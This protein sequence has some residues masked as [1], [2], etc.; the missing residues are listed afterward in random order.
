M[1][2]DYTD[3][4]PGDAKKPSRLIVQRRPASVW[5]RISRPRAANALSPEVI[6]AMDLA[7]TEAHSQPETRAVVI[8]GAGEVFC[9]GADVVLAGEMLSE[10]RADEF[11]SYME[12]ANE[13]LDRIEDYPLP[14]IAAVN[15]AA[16]A[17]GLELVLACDL[18]VAADNARIGDA[19][20]RHGFVP[21]WGASRRLPAALGPVRARR[22]MLTGAS[23]PAADLP[24]LFNA[25]VPPQEVETEVES[26]VAEIAASGPLAITAIK[27]LLA[28]DP[29]AR[30]ATRRREGNALRRQME[31]REL[32]EGIAA[33]VAGHQPRFA[34][35]VGQP[36]ARRP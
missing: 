4:P 31:T 24:E 10:G 23:I 2:N 1:P 14:V 22:L 17:G 6:A 35:S 33:F 7:L 13:L 27:Q 19:H 12:A 32:A 11:T 26:L 30:A 5:L 3:A 20:A 25:V 34:R 21:A 8:T 28:G 9:A 29:A 16:L 18:A 15:G 36:Q